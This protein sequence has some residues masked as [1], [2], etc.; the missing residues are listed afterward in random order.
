MCSLSCRPEYTQCLLVNFE[1]AK[2]SQTL[3]VLCHSKSD[4]TSGA[5]V[6]RHLGSLPIAASA[7]FCKQHKL[8]KW[9]SF[10]RKWQRN[11]GGA[12]SWVATPAEMQLLIEQGATITAKTRLLKSQVIGTLFLLLSHFMSVVMLHALESACTLCVQI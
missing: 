3:Y 7:S 8:D 10:A 5:L 12:S 2:K 4:T 6:A 11:S 1:W 9:V